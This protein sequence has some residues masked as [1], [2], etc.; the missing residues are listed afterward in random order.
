MLDKT[1]IRSA[2]GDDAVALREIYRPFVENSSI[3]FELE[4]PSVSEFARRINSAV[5]DWAWLVAEIDGKPI[6]YAYGTTHRARP[7]Y[8]FS[9]ETSA[10]IDADYCRYGI[11]SALYKQ[12]LK[13]LSEQGFGNAYAGITLPNEASVGFHKSLGFKTIGV[14]PRVGKKFGQWHDVAWLHRRLPD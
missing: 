12:L 8:R 3:S 7:A 10:Y 13:A 11:A 9:V 14:F 5:Q 6:G 2:S 1:I 4:T